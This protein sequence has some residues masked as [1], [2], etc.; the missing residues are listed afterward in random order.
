[1]IKKRGKGW[2]GRV[3]G[4]WICISA[5]IIASMFSRVSRSRSPPTPNPN[6]KHK[7]GLD[8]LIPSSPAS[9]P[10][11]FVRPIMATKRVNTV[12]IHMSGP[13]I[14]EFQSNNLTSPYYRGAEFTLRRPRVLAGVSWWGEEGKSRISQNGVDLA[15]RSGYTKETSKLWWAFRCSGPRIL[16]CF[17]MKS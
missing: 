5:Q 14:T 4:F 11:V 13:G 2:W 16:G 6:R 9:A 7:P 15:N 17:R 8:I 12:E 10:S 3:I 1:M